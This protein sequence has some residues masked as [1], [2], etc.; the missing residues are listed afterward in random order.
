TFRD[1]LTGFLRTLDRDGHE[2]DRGFYLEAW[3][4]SGSYTYDR[5]GRGTIHI[6]YACVS[7][8]GTIQPGPLARY[9]RATLSQNDGLMNRFQLLLYPDPPG[10]WVNVDRYP[11]AAA[12]NEAFRVFKDLDAFDP[13]GLGVE[14]DDERGIPFLRFAPDAQELFD[15]W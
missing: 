9:V 5:I 8:F 3:N 10:R 13:R 14:V 6:P 1:E 15:E 4:G 7:L 12:K 11:D 2:N